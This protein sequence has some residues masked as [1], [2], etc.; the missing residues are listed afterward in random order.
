M[1]AILSAKQLCDYKGLLP[2][3]TYWSNIFQF[4]LLL[5]EFLQIFEILIMFND[6]IQ[7]VNFTD[8]ISNAYSN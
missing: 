5:P 7:W 6:Q 8:L 3:A 4:V 1:G 2:I